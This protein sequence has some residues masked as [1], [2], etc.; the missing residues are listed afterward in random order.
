M[1]FAVPSLRRGSWP[2]KPAERA[3][4]SKSATS[5]RAARLL[6][7][8]EAVFERMSV[9]LQPADQVEIDRSIAQVRSELDPEEL[10]QYWAEGRALSFEEAIA[11]AQVG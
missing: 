2:R 8:A 9:S 11:Y 3:R 10:E 7:A 1:S 5:S 6:G 4:R